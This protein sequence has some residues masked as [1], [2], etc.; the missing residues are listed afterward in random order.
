MSN[1]STELKVGIF[2]IIVIMILSYI[3]FKVGSLPLIWEKGYR[4][5]ADFDDIS[6]LDEQSRI[7][8]AGVETG[9][10]EKINLE[11][12]R[13]RITLLIEPDIKVYKNAIASLRMSGLLGDRYLSIHTGSSDQPLLKTGDVI[14]HTRPAADTRAAKPKLATLHLISTGVRFPPKRHSSKHTSE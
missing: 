5:Y 7:K 2:A 6:G 12:G 9:V 4:L 10:V 3:T 14:A 8:I 1:T 13:A 11:D